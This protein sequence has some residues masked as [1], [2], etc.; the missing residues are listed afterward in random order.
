MHGTDRLHALDAVRAFALL[1]GIVLHAAMAFLPGLF[2]GIWS[3]VDASPSTTL[4]VAFFTIHMFRMSLFFLL[5]GFFGH[6]TFHRKGQ[7]AFMADRAK[8]ILI[9]LVVG[10]VVLYPIIGLV[11][12]WGYQRL[13]GGPAPEMPANFRPA[14]WFPFTHLWFLYMLALLYVIA[15]ATR[16][17]FDKVIDRNETVRLC[18]DAAMRAIAPGIV[19]PA[20]LALPIAISLYA[21]SPWIAWFG[22]PSPDVTYLPAVP[23]FIGFGSAFGVGWLL[24]R[25][26]GLL[27]GWARHAFVY[28]GAAI[29]CTVGCLVM[30]G[31][32]PA[33]VPMPYGGQKALYVALYAIGSWNWMAGIIGLGLRYLSIENRVLRYL[34][35]SSYWL[36]LIHLPIVGALNVIVGPWH[37]HWAIK[38]PFILGVSVPLML[39]SYHV[40]VR[41]S[42]IGAILN[43]RRRRRHPPVL[44]VPAAE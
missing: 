40:L 24:H 44:T 36:Y 13:T 14:H 33:F 30:A 20:L 42:F 35:D 2:P 1:A 11:W 7:G 4:S 12:S 17:L 8:R 26:V 19:G 29:A 27:T 10:W 28:L 18:L 23:A 3:Y 15:L 5:A 38:F 16:L 32:A 21:Q 22:V 41:Y 25:Q 31:T 43:G 6:M 34:A 39:L 37:I 9:P